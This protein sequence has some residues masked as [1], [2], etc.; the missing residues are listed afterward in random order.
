M[1]GMT[2]VK[3]LM[4]RSGSALRK[5]AALLAAIQIVLAAIPLTESASASASA[6]VESTGERSH[7]A[8]S[9]EHCIACVA[10]RLFD[11][12]APAD[13]STLASLEAS[14][15]AIAVLS[16]SFDPGPTSS[17]QRSRAPPAT[18]VG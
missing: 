11:G 3:L 18:L 6:H 10:L 14:A 9:E 2:V 4:V 1:R 5:A 15:A 12:A 16:H 13:A 7:H 17:P 8:H